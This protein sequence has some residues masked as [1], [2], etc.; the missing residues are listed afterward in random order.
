MEDLSL[1]AEEFG[2]YEKRITRGHSTL[3]KSTKRWLRSH[4]PAP[5]PMGSSQWR[6]N[7]TK[8]ARLGAVELRANSVTQCAQRWVQHAINFSPMS[9]T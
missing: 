6:R 5:P 8:N 4:S 9:C 7:A 1:S 3:W 2:V